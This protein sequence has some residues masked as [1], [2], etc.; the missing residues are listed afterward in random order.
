M[1]YVPKRN[2]HLIR[3]SLPTSHGF[4]PYPR[5]GEKEIF[6]PLLVASTNKNRFEVLFDFVGTLDVSPYICIIEALKFRREVCGGEEKIM[7]YCQNI[8]VEAAEHCA[9]TLGTDYMQNKEGTLTKCFMVNIRLPL[10]IGSNEGE[11][12]EKDTYAVAVWMTLRMADEYDMYSPVFIHAGKFWTRWCGQ[13][14]L[15]MA[16]YAKGAEALKT[17]CERAKKGEYLK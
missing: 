17:M 16:D 15:E 3:S 9:R 11:I 5:A 7:D 14:Y 2:Q 8:S 1:F 6:N 12:A 13:I 10:T 4:E